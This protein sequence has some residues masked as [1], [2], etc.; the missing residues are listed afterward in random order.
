MDHSAL[1]TGARML[2]F[3]GRDAT[4]GS[5]TYFG[6]GWSF[7]PI[8]G[9]WSPI[10]AAGAPEARAV[11][12][13]A[14]T[15][16]SMLVWGGTNGFL[17]LTTGG[18]YDPGSDTWTATAPLNEFFD[19]F[20]SV[21]TASELIVYGGL[22]GS[23]WR[24]SAYDPREDL[25]KA[26]P[27][28]GQPG[29]S[30][31]TRGIEWTCDRVYTIGSVSDANASYDPGTDLWSPIAKNPLA[32]WLSQARDVVAAG[33]RLL[34]W[35]GD[36]GE[37]YCACADAPAGPRVQLFVGDVGQPN[38]LTW[39]VDPAAS[40][41]DLVRGDLGVLRATGGDFTASTGTCVANDTTGVSWTESDPVPSA[42]FWYLMRGTYGGATGSFD[43]GAARQIGSRDAEIAASGFACP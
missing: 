33:S 26:I 25:W 18:R 30:T 10:S 9:V 43:S 38:R 39:F 20:D 28:S 32:P 27:Q 6:D 24:G 8:G 5:P 1:W 12:A 17:S 31:T 37:S 22:P 2:L 34:V 19:S 4:S 42:G 16:G 7:D 13:A 23:P 36:G 21:W 35:P 3:G 15:G 14:W 41:Y 40:S 11:H 29:T